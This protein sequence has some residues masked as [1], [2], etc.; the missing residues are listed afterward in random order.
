MKLIKRFRM[1]QKLV[2]F[3]VCRK[4]YC[5]LNFFVYQFQRNKKR[6]VFRFRR[7]QIVRYYTT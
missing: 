7:S 5:T 4:N 2:K 1:L 6:N 3:K